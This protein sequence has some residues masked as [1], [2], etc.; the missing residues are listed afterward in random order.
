[1]IHLFQ[2]GVQAALFHGGKALCEPKTV[3]ER[4]VKD[5][6]CVFETDLLFDIQVGDIPRM[7]RIC[8]VVYEMCKVKNMRAKRLRDSHNQVSR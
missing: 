8:F 6:Q 7:A 1:M 3:T 2:V 4:L 5:G